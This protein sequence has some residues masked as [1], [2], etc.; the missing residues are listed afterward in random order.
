MGFGWKREVAVYIIT[1]FLES[2]KTSFI[3]ETMREGQFQDGLTTL[4]LVM[5]EGIEEL[6]SDLLEKNRFTLLTVD[7][8]DRLTT[9]FFKKLDKKY[10]PERVLI[11]F[12]GTWNVDE[13]I[14]ALPDNW[15]IGQGIALVDASTYSAYL[16][17]MKM[18]IL[19]QFTYADLIIFNRCSEDMD[20]AGYKRSARA[21]NRRSQV[22]FEMR[23]GTINNNIKEELPY[24]I[25]APRI[26]IEDDDFGIWYLD[27]YENLD[28]YKGKE[29]RFKGQVYKP[30]K[31]PP[32][33]FVPGRFCMTCCEADIQFVGFPCKYEGA[34]RL[35]ERDF[36][37]VT[38]KIDEAR[39]KADGQRAPLLRA[40][41]IEKAEP[42]LEEVVLFS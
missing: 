14:E 7:D 11:E 39:S 2:G 29:V 27:V 13:L 10:R 24:D 4:C 42:P 9:S 36:V 25:N 5:E 18:M 37:Y 26:D 15:L 41:G 21:K 19:N 22:L 28:N 38:A 12:N 23:D 1:G 30:D 40:T 8:E 17:N 34:S 31:A 35:K 16:A 32:A 3:R 33:M 20:L 6:E